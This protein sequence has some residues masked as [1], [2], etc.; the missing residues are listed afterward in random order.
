MILQK[1]IRFII[2]CRQKYTSQILFIFLT[3]GNHSDMIGG[4][5]VVN[6]GSEE[7]LIKAKMVKSNKL[8]EFH[9]FWKLTR[10]WQTI[11]GS[12]TVICS[13]SR[14]VN[15]MNNCCSTYFGSSSFYNCT[16]LLKSPFLPF[17]ERIFKIISFL[18][19]QHVLENLKIIFLNIKFIE[20]SLVKNLFLNCTLLYQQPGKYYANSEKQYQTIKL[21]QTLNTS[22]NLTHCFSH[23]PYLT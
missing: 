16:I 4:R 1:N 18:I 9:T 10:Q 7:A 17:S 19:F 15:V 8:I 6:T 22:V 14:D 11:K 13:G 21:K 23:I 5:M 20:Q 12:C 2:L 3:Y